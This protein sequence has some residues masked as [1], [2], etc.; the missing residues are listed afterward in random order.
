[1]ENKKLGVLM[2]V[3][4]FIFLVF[5]IYYG[6]SL[7]NKSDNANCNPTEECKSFRNLLTMTNI[8][9]GFFGFLFALGFY[10]L[11][12]NKTDERIFRRLE[13][14]KNKKIS[15]EKFDIILKAL[16]EYEKKVLKIIKEQDGITQNTLRLRANLSKAKLSYVVQELERR[17]LIKRIPKGKTLGVYLRV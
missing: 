17:G 7:S 5:L 9:F 14:E 4:S 6:M 3:I 12:F 8:G 10:L 13:D 2:I 15:E 1:M 16:D 11:F